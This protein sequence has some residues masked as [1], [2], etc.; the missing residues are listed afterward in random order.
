MRPSAL[1]CTGLHVVQETAP[2]RVQSQVDWLASMQL[3][4]EELAYLYTKSC[5]HVVSIL[6]LF[7]FV[8]FLKGHSQFLYFSRDLY[9]LLPFFF[10][11]IT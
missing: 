7:P 4:S 1:V 11:V 8:H 6:Y 3:G 10:L 5:S 2:A 9:L